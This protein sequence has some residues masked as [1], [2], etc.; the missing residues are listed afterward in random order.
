MSAIPQTVGTAAGVFAVTNV[1]GLVILLGLHVSHRNGAGPSARQIVI[2]QYLGFA[3]L[4]GLAATFACGLTNVPPRWLCLVGL[5][6]I[7][8][9][10]RGLWLLR[11]LRPIPAVDRPRA[12]TLAS[13]CLTTVASGFDNISVYALLFRQLEL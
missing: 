8:I 11:V 13:T 6:P 7:T 1:D 4:I 2:G 10:L 12:T 3:A 5:M 9:G